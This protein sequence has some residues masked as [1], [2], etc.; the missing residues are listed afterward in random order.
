MV[1]SDN[2]RDFDI[3]PAEHCKNHST[4]STQWHFINH[5]KS[6]WKSL[7]PFFFF[8]FLKGVFSRALRWQMASAAVEGYL[9]DTNRVRQQGKGGAGLGGGAL[10]EVQTLICMMGC[11]TTH[12]AVLHQPSTWRPI[13]VQRVMEGVLLITTL[14]GWLDGGEVGGC[15]GSP[16]YVPS[17]VCSRESIS[18]PRVR[19]CYLRKRCSS[20]HADGCVCTH[21]E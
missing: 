11:N 21:T 3:P 16:T 2:F 10:S 7:H 15:W 5:S 14:F 18:L 13:C 17:T 8:F 12:S 19:S 6:E 1:C 20:R 4:V 9:K